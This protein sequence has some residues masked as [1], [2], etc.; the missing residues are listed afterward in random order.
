[1]SGALV[2]F[3]RVALHG[4]APADETLNRQIGIEYTNTGASPLF[5]V[6]SIGVLNPAASDSAAIYID[7]V[8]INY[9]TLADRYGSNSYLSRVCTMSFFVPVGSTYKID[10]FAGQ[11][12][13]V[14]DWFE[15]E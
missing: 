1:M 10:Q 5:V 6:A 12:V 15:Y 8:Q 9:Q 4:K 3:N 14:Y 11:N 13:Y 7:G 2:S